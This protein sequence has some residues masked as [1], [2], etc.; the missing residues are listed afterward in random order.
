MEDSLKCI[1]VDDEEG[2]HLVLKQ[3]IGNLQYLQFAGSFYTA[4]EAMGHVYNNRVD[5]IF[6]DINM[7]GLSGL[8]MLQTLSDPPLVILT[9]AYREYA[10]EGYKYRVVDYLVKP[11]NFPRF[12]AAIDAAFSRLK[13]RQIASAPL[14][15]PASLMLKVEGEMIRVMYDQI[16]YIRSWGNYVKVFTTS[17]VH[18]SAATTA[19]IEQKLDKAKFRRIHKSYIVAIGRIS[20]VTPGQALLEDGTALPVGA[21]YRRDLAACFEIK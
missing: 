6:L 9:T 7:P 5:L 2:A 18:L 17:G 21:T 8:E 12:V 20:K 10:L 16:L 19:E 3:Y 4:V 13:P 15:T 14:I 11:F 1:I